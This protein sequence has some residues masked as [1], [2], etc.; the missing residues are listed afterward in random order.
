MDWNNVKILH[1][2]SNSK[3][4]CVAEMYYMKK[5]KHSINKMT[6]LE[7]FSHIYFTVLK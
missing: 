3:K 7:E 5:E 4:R 6:H 1:K 2:E